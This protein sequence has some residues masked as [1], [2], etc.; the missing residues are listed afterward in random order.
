LKLAV[1]LSNDILQ[2]WVIHSIIIILY[3]A[4][5]KAQLR[6]IGRLTV[7]SSQI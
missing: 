6:V 5:N 2:I 7:F 3:I 4:V 1:A